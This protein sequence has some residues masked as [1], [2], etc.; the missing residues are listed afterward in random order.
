M[1]GAMAPHVRMLHIPG[2]AS[3]H[4]QPEWLL[5][6]FGHHY[7]V[8]GDWAS[9][10]QVVNHVGRSCAAYNDCLA[11]SFDW[12][13]TRRN[14]RLWRYSKPGLFPCKTCA[15]GY[16]SPCPSAISDRGL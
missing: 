16:S 12:N 3:W 10:P 15:T 1:L 2:V 13:R 4:N 9:H 5:A 7:L 14:F 11:H 8:P 6:A